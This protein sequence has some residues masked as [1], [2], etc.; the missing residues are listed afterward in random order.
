MSIAGTIQ[1]IDI[2]FIR[3]IRVVIIV[4]VKNTIT[5]DFILKQLS[6]SQILCKLQRSLRLFHKFFFFNL[7]FLT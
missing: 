7:N 3:V 6:D 4:N 5:V 1:F 2:H